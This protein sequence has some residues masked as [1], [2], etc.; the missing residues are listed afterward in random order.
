MEL[1]NRSVFRA[2]R[3]ASRVSRTPQVCG[4]GV[5]SHLSPLPLPS[6]GASSPGWAPQPR[7][8]SRVLPLCSEKGSGF[9]VPSSLTLTAR[10][11]SGRPATAGCPCQSCS[12]ENNRSS[13][14]RGTTGP[15]DG[16][17][18]VAGAV[19]A[20]GTRKLSLCVPSRPPAPV[21]PVGPAQHSDSQRESLVGVTEACVLPCN[22]GAD[23]RTASPPGSRRAGEGVMPS[24]DIA[25]SQESS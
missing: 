21:A 15:W 1:G 14:K 23:D 18:R 3:V 24:P 25:G 13:G 12:A 16:Q 8:L 6:S 10:Q 9:T 20:R 22:V 5:S 4:L 11:S 17:S 19:W 2:C 7:W